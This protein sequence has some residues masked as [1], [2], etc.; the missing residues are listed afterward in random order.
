MT[1]DTAIP[2]PKL[3]DRDRAHSIIETSAERLG[4]GL[5]PTGDWYLDRDVYELERQA[6]FGR[7]WQLV[8]PVTDI[9]E[10]GDYTSVELDERTQFIVVRSRDGK[11]RAFRNVCP[12]RGSQ[13]VGGK[14]DYAPLAPPS[15]NVPFIRCTYHGWTYELDGSLR[16]APMID[17]QEGFPA[18]QYGLLEAAVDTWGPFVFL[19][20]DADA[21]PLSEHLGRLPELV[22]GLGIDLMAVAK[23]ANLKRIEGTLEANWKIAV[24]NALECYHCSSSHPGLLDTLELSKWQMNLRGNCIIQGT[25]VRDIDPDKVDERIETR[26]GKLATTAALSADGFGFAYFHFILPNNSVSLWPGPGNSFNI[27]RWIPMGPART[28]WWMIRWWPKDV[29]DAVRDDQWKFISDVGWE[30]QE[31]VENQQKGLESQAWPGG[32]YYL[33]SDDAAPDAAPRHI[34]PAEMAETRDERGVHQLNR[35]IADALLAAQ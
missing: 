20:P 13:L 25:R 28:K 10:P 29:S 34:D 23:E 6:I 18:Y 7:T 14:R 19:N 22:D 30:D 5:S 9:P 12:H 35:L 4:Q 2:G 8:C 17:R 21:A 3:V 32:P 26:L 16:R 33:S 1:T 31:I 24:E 11:V 15:G 27:A